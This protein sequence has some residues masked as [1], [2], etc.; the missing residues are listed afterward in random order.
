MKLLL[1]IA[2]AM[3][4][5][6]VRPSVMAAQQSV[7]FGFLGAIC[8]DGIKVS[9]DGLKAFC[10]SC[11]S[12][13][14]LGG[15][16]EDFRFDFG[17]PGPF[18]AYPNESMFVHM[19]GCGEMR[20][21]WEWNYLLNKTEKGW[22]QVA[23]ESVDLRD[24]EQIAVSKTAHKILCEQGSIHT[25]EYDG[26]IFA[27]FPESGSFGSDETLL[28]TIDS[29]PTCGY[30]GKTT[31]LEVN[32]RI[33]KRQADGHDDVSLVVSYGAGKHNNTDCRPQTMKTE[34]LNFLGGYTG[35]KPDS[36]TAKKIRHIYQVTG[37]GD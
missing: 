1:K 37:I 17:I 13:T 26:R 16:K 33:I 31:I 34:T 25:G 6:L 11:P 32:K 10:N 18:G 30:D 21:S 22:V 27:L 9:T 20:D 2:L 4:P 14:P 24:C 23:R 3:A 19:V 28:H 35:L 15:V 7:E 29:S 12:Y 8:E 36:Q 5:I